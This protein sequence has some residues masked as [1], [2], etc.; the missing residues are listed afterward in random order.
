MMDFK[1]F[2]LPLLVLTGLNLRA[3]NVDSLLKILPQA[4]DTN[5]VI[6]LDAISNEYNNR[7]NQKSID[8]AIEAYEYAKKINNKK[9]R[10]ST[11]VMLG[12][13]YNSLGDYTTAIKYLIE[14]M[15]LY[16][17]SKNYKGASRAANALGNLYLGQGNNTKAL[18][19]YNIVVR[20]GKLLKAD[21]TISLGYMGVSSVYS[22]TG[23]LD[24]ALEFVNKAISGFTMVKRDFETLACIINKA[25]ILNS[26][27]RDREAYDVYMG[28]LPTI[29]KMNDKYFLSNVY[30]NLGTTLINL[31]KSKEGLPY[32]RKA[33]VVNKEL[34]AYAN[35]VTIFKAMAKAFQDM[36]KMDSAYFYLDK[37]VVLKDSLYKMENQQQINELE[38]KY[39]MDKKNSQL[40]EKEAQLVAQVAQSKLK[41]AQQAADDARNGLFRNVLIVIL[42]SAVV[43]L[44]FVY[45]SNIHKKKAYKEV[46]LQKSIVEQKNT[47][48]LDSIEYA[49]R[50][51]R[52]LLASDTFLKKQLNDHFILYKPK[53]IVSGDFYWASEII[54]TNGKRNFMMCTADCTGHGVPGAFMSLLCISFLNEITRNGNIIQPNEVFTKLKQEIVLSLNPDEAVHTR[55][56]MDAVLCRFDFDNLQL[57][58]ACANNPVLIVRNHEVIEIKPDKNPIGKNERTGYDYTLHKVALQK[59]DQ[60]YTFTD[61]Y[62]DQ[63]GGESGKKFKYRQFKEMIFANRLLSMSEQKT[64]LEAVIE[65]WKG[66]LEQLDD[67]LVIGIRV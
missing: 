46:S 43:V 63:F 51:Q 58:M 31:G 7:D 66:N 23:E 50:I 33:L 24:K 40:K 22:N 20:F 55:D 34:K 11:S 44:F 30:L 18:E 28:V 64:K 12:N 62:A 6:I 10:G 35:E 32:L 61:G 27:K 21:Y 59:G 3:Q 36:R 26:L 53:D 65:K 2:I 25:T 39:Q 5:R 17:S 41:D 16:E 15:N 49:R 14:G 37:C 19:Y 9:F 60:V 67:I 29:E 1:K 8:Y 54:D 57:E 38:T 13:A 4:K 45:R 56:G 52:T 42:L 48:I 47:E